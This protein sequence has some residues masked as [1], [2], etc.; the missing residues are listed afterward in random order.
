MK[1]PGQ[2]P[3]QGLLAEEV[4]GSEMQSIFSLPS[5]DM[6]QGLNQEEEGDITLISLAKVKMLHVLYD[7]GCL[8]HVP[9][10]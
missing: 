6:A 5:H 1:G 8:S 9:V 4:I 10:R 2:K 7:V 3:A